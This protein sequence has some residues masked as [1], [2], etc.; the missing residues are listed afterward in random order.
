MGVQRRVYRRVEWDFPRDFPARLALFK[1]ASGL[2]WKRLARL[3]GVSPC[4]LWEWRERGVVPSPGHLF[5]LLTIAESMGLL[6]G[7]FICPDRDM[8]DAVK[9]LLR[10]G[11][12]DEN[13]AG[14][15]HGRER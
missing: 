11:C 12:A 6:D 9:G 2:S 5:L 7:I 13:G 15:R 10:E 14:I 4:R 1:E 3:L 8:P